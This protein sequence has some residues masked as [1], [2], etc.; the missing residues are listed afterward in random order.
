VQKYEFDQGIEGNE[1]PWP[2][3]TRYQIGK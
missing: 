2:K 3:G 1:Q